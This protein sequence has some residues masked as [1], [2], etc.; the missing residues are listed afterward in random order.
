M[1]RK[2]YAERKLAA[3]EKETALN[4]NRDGVLIAAGQIWEDCNPR[5]K[6]RTLSISTVTAGVAAAFDGKRSTDILVTKMHPHSR[7]YQPWGVKS[8]ATKKTPKK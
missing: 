6:G 2:T 4:T 5:A 8:A 7:G 1:A 3:T